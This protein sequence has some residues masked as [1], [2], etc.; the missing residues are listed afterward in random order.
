MHILSVASEEKC[1]FK[2][3]IVGLGIHEIYKG[4]FKYE[5]GDSFLKQERQNNSVEG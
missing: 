2:R 1:I 4:D 5:N 3:T